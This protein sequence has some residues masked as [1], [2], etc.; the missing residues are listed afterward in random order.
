MQL[1]QEH[2]EALS[3]VDNEHK[4]G[5]LATTMDGEIHLSSIRFALT[6]RMDVAIIYRAAT[7]KSA[8]I[9]KVPRAAFQLDNRQAGSAPQDA[10]SFV[11]AT[12]IGPVEP[13]NAGSAEFEEVKAMY[14][15][16]IP[17]AEPFFKAPDIQLCLLRSA[18]IRFNKGVGKPT[19]VLTP[20]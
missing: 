4:F 6:S 15:R 2:I 5:V 1:T 13:L 20:A 19:E 11:R 8:N 14:L 3:S 10:T 9:A 18:Q 17:E 12:F 16:K 7:L